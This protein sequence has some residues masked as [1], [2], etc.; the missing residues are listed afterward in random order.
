MPDTP[1]LLTF[2]DARIEETEAHGLCLIVHLEDGTHTL[3]IEG[4]RAIELQDQLNQALT[5][6]LRAAWQ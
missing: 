1:N 6:R 3:C 5:R 4:R 2:A